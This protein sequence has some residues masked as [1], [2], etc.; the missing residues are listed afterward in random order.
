[1]LGEI[2]AGLGRVGQAEF[3]GRG[4]AFR[5]QELL[6][7]GFKGILFQEESKGWESTWK[8]NEALAKWVRQQITLDVQ[9]R[10]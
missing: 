1:M 10:L 5:R 6:T 2:S 3:T 9:L 8:E 4:V 7:D